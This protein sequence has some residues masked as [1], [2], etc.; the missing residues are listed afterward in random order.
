MG[1]R[2]PSGRGSTFRLPSQPFVL[3]PLMLLTPVE[4]SNGRS[5]EEQR[6]VDRPVTA[7]RV[8]PK[9]AR[10]RLRGCCPRVTPRGS[11]RATLGVFVRKRGTR[12]KA[13]AD[14]IKAGNKPQ[15]E[16][17]AFLNAP[18]C[19]LRR[20][21]MRAVRRRLP[22]TRRHGEIPGDFPVPAPSSRHLFCPNF[23]RSSSTSAWER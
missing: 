23:L 5:F 7:L 4:R 6:P 16:V 14:Q 1:I 22:A 9:W 8:R 15:R 12:G 18:E 17:E 19:R 3:P 21:F 20:H 11:S 10:V 2:L 13:K